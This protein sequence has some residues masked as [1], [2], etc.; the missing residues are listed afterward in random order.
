MIRN[1]G[2]NSLVVHAALPFMDINQ[3]VQGGIYVLYNIS[4]SSFFRSY[5]ICQSTAGRMLFYILLYKIEQSVTPKPIN[6]DITL[7]C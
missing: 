6:H 5:K 3:V 1:K 2:T 4:V 7:R